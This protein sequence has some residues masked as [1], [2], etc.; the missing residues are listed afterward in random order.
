MHCGKNP[1]EN[2]WKHGVGMLKKYFQSTHPCAQP[3]GC[4]QL[5]ISEKE[6][7]SGLENL[8]T[9]W[10]SKLSTACVQMDA[11]CD[12]AAVQAHHAAW[13]EPTLQHVHL[14]CCKNYFFAVRLVVVICNFVYLF[15]KTPTNIADALWCLCIFL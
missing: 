3:A 8:F 9:F 10:C 4:T 11:A 2:P 7:P 14:I 15:S 1:V 6:S 12:G 13:M 5:W